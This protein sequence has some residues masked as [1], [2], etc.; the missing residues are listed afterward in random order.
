MISLTIFE[1][2]ISFE[3]QRILIALSILIV[4]NVLYLMLSQNMKHFTSNKM[5]Y[6]TTWVTIAVVLGVCLMYNDE[7]T[8]VSLKDSKYHYKK[9]KRDFVY[10]GILIALLVYIPIFGW[11]KSVG[12]IT[13]LQCLCFSAFGIIISAIASL[14]TYII[15]VK[16]N[17]H[18]V[19]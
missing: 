14:F 6:L 2:P 12:N 13:G 5:A 8:E 10:F 7:E 4:G 17:L 19:D 18:P 16:N 3:I 11:L 15:S 1:G 9:A